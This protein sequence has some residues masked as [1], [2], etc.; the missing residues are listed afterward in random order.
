MN[1]QHHPLPRSRPTQAAGRHVWAHAL[2]WVLL[3]VAAVLLVGFIAL[4]NDI[5]ERGELRHAQQR[6]SGSLHPTRAPH[7]HGVYM[8]HLLSIVGQKLAVRSPRSASL[9]AH[10]P[11]PKLGLWV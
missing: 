1:T 10:G 6:L 5:T 2:I 9:N 4:V 11:S 8:P 7:T 3:A